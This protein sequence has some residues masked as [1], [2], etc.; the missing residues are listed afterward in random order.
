MSRPEQPPAPTL[1][2]WQALVLGAVHGPAELLP[3]SSSGHTS[4]IPW[5]LGWS[6][7]ELEAAQRKSFEV[8]LHAGTAAALGLSASRALAA[9][10]GRVLGLIAA[11]AVPPAVTGFALEGVIENRLGTP[12]SIAAGLV[13]GSAAMVLADCTPQRRRLREATVA[14]A[15]LM[16][17]AQSV[18]LIPGISRHGAT[19]AAARWRRFKRAD[20]YRFSDLVGVAPVLGATILRAARRP[21]CPAM[22]PAFAAGAGAAF[23]STLISARRLRPLEGPLRPFAGYR[24]ALAAVIALRVRGGSTARRRRPARP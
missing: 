16:G 20:S 9:V 15:L 5:L 1:P 3:I 21:V 10:D 12:A 24:L 8:A 17:V 18:A 7:G 22:R 23:A 2:V 11:S 19:L 14:D 4:A 6:Y 13:V